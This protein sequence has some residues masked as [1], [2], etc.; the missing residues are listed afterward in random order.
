LTGFC[1]EWLGKLPL[2]ELERAS[3]LFDIG[4]VHRAT[5]ARLKRIADLVLVLLGLAVASAP[6]RIG[7]SGRFPGYETLRCAVMSLPDQ[8]AKRRSVRCPQRL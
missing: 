8:D 5:Y 6:S 1:S 7:S 4:D 2:S 3:L